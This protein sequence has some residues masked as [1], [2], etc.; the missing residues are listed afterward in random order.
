[1]T[2][3]IKLRYYKENIGFENGQF[4]KIGHF[5][6]DLALKSKNLK[7]T[8]NK[9]KRS[10]NGPFKKIRDLKKNPKNKNCNIIH[11]ILVL[12]QMNLLRND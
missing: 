5:K 8:H 4:T 6:T 9:N 12:S 10:Y 3:N 11:F 1:M 7:R 2:I